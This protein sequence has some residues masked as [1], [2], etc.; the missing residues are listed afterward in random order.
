MARVA[1]PSIATGQSSQTVSR[2][3][4]GHGHRVRLVSNPARYE[5]GWGTWQFVTLGLTP[6]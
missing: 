6:K 1:A 5:L 3:G 2:S 4:C